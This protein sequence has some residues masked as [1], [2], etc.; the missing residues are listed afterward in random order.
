MFDGI[1]ILYKFIKV[2]ISEKDIYLLV[3]QSRLTS[4]D[5]YFKSFKDKLEKKKYLSGIIQLENKVNRSEKFDTIQNEVEIH[6]VSDGSQ[7]L[8]STF[9][10]RF[11]GLISIAIYLNGISLSRNCRIGFGS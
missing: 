8:E 11:D 9:E 7:Y 10:N 4:I 2:H 6:S 5:K 3:R 1:L